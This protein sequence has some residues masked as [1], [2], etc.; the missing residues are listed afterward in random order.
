MA[1]AGIV[2][3]EQPVNMDEKCCMSTHRL[4]LKRSSTSGRDPSFRRRLR[5]ATIAVA[6]A[7]LLGSASHP[8]HFRRVQVDRDTRAAM[9]VMDLTFAVREH[10]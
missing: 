7:I 2:L 9:H 10:G 6:A 3:H 5:W 1:A 8:G 4:D